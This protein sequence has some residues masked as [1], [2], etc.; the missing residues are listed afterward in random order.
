MRRKDPYAVAADRLAAI[1]EDPDTPPVL[2]EMVTQICVTLDSF[3]ATP[4]GARGDLLP[5]DYRFR[6]RCDD[7]TTPDELRRE[8]PGMLRKARDWQVIGAYELLEGGYELA[9]PAGEGGEQ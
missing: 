5:D 7:P 8:L 4:T 9:A 1:L 3:T 6:L 2:R